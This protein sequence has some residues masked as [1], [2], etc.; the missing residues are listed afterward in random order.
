VQNQAGELWE[1][2]H[3]AP[4]PE[5]SAA[6]SFRLVVSKAVPGRFAAAWSGGP[7]TY[8]V[9]SDGTL[10]E[11]EQPLNSYSNIPVG[12]WRQVGKRSDWTTLW[13]GGGTAM[14]LTHDGTIWTWGIDVGREPVP[15]FWSRFKL[16]QGRLITM[17]GPT[18]RPMLA[19]ATP[20]YQKQP[21]PLMRLVFTNSMR[22]AE[23]GTAGRK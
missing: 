5:A 16:A 1:P 17:V 10:W 3:A 18:P 6:S 2:F 13:G 8:E 9:R 15:D 14:G 11:R 7:R 19:G 20:A 21:R 12:E 22:A 23:A 4:N